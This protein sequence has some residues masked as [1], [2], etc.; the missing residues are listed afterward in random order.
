MAIT[1]V[2]DKLNINETKRIY[3]LVGEVLDVVGAAGLSREDARTALSSAL[4]M[5]PY[6][7]PGLIRQSESSAST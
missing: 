6:L 2:T 1:Y 5:I 7:D 3:A 4:E